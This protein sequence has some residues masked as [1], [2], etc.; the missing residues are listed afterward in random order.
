MKPIASPD[1]NDA[2]L[3]HPIFWY[4]FALFMLVLWPII[5]ANR[6]YIDDMGRAETGFMGWSSDGRPLANVLMETVNL[7]TP[8]TDMAPLL[9]LLSIALLA[10]AT[11]RIA[12][13]FGLNAPISAVLAAFPLGAS[14]F[15]LENLSYRFD[16]LPMTV[17]VI[18]AVLP[19]TAA[20]R[21]WRA[22]S[23][24]WGVFLLLASLC[25]YQPAANVFIVLVL[26]DVLVRQWH[27]YPWKDIL[28]RVVARMAQLGV[29]LVLYKGVVAWKVKGA[30]AQT[31]GKVE[32]STL[33]QTVGK[34]FDLF[35]R[36][37]IDGLPGGMG[38]ILL[39]VVVLG[40]LLAIL[41]GGRYV[42]HAVRAGDRSAT[43]AALAAWLLVPASL[44]AAPWGVL[45]ILSDPVINPRIMIGF[46]AL[47]CLTLILIAL[48]L[49]TLSIKAVW[50][51]VLLGIPA[52]VMVMF[53]FIYGNALRL[54]NEFEARVSTS[55]A[56]DAA[57]IV[58]RHPG[59][60]RY[61][62]DGSVGRPPIVAHYINKYPLLARLVPE[63]INAHWGWT[64]AQLRMYGMEMPTI[65]GW[66]G[67]PPDL[68]RICA[69][70][71]LE[72]DPHYRLYLLDKILVIS[73]NKDNV[74]R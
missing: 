3:H 10:Y 9:Q 8:L 5:N 49:Q 21:A 35:W 74:C 18:L 29:A 44:L 4:A 52:V 28:G 55:L 51:R 1:R 24:A 41:I 19:A 6:Y 14:P 7:G 57:D 32:L 70:T 64:D 20:G 23:L 60:E 65:W 12:R 33:P 68:H 15:F 40:V 63:H 47:L 43:L 50:Q 45:L 71:P 31:H 46:G 66:K 59:I 67:T 39:G 38:G 27:D 13:H 37:V 62:L 2:S 11:V 58:L 25:F 34:N 54:Q 22:G 56:D 53:A 48:L 17:A 69:M 30:Y 42:V 26:A 36:V 61:M 72:V 16:A 73:L